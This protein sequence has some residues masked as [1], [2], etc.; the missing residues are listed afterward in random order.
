MRVFKV[1]EDV[2]R[3]KNGYLDAAHKWG[4]PGVVC[5]VC[6]VTWG[7]S[8]LEYPSV[9]LTS[10]PNVSRYKE[11][12]PVPLETYRDM[13]DE[14]WKTF[15]HLPTLLPGTALGP[16]QGKIKGGRVKDF[17]W[18]SWWT[19]SLESTAYERLLNSGL[20]LPKVVKAEIVSKKNPQEVLEFDLPL[21]AE[22][23]NGIY[24]GIQLDFCIACGRNS[25]TLPEQIVI[26]VSSVSGSFD[27]FRIRNFTTIVLVTED[28]VEV[29]DSFGLSGAIFQEVEIL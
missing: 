23:T 14:L 21:E 26:D 15:P 4:L 9:D 19:I 29:V 5:P 25:A 22:L 11:P 2:L 8:G 1:G 24:D 7:V 17:V 6:G 10:F 20:S 12:W 3:Q 16:S 13:R 27:I 18:G 28:F